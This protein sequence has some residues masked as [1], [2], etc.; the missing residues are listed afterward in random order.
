MKLGISIY[1]ISR[2]I[3]KKEIT[4]EEAIQRLTDIGANMIEIVPFGMDEINSDKAFVKRLKE[5]SE[6]CGTPIANYSLNANFLQIEEEARQAEIDRVCTHM[7]AAYALGAKTMRV[8]ASS[9]RRALDT[10]DL[11]HFIDELPVIADSYAKLCT[12]AEKLGLTV[13]IENHG[14]HLN[15]SDRVEAMLMNMKIGNLSL[16]LDVGNFV[17]VDENPLVAVQR[18]AAE[19]KTVHMKDFYIRDKDRDP[20]DATQFDCSGSWFRSRGGMYLRGSILGQGDMDMVKIADILKNS[21][22]DGDVY[23][24]YEGIE[25]CMYGTTVGFNNMKRFFA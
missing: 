10:V 24:E 23:L 5:A 21:G 15:G 14:F 13:L 4:P 20:G 2:L 6:S 1:S 17:C 18:L 12:Y 22:F 9:Y 3:V 25:E 11:M 8:D 7:E 16:Q 19:A